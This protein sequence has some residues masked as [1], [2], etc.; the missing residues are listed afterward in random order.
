MAPLKNCVY[1]TLK[2]MDKNTKHT[3]THTN[4]YKYADG[5]FRVDLFVIVVAVFIP[6]GGGWLAWV[7]PFLEWLWELVQDVLICRLNNEIFL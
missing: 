2:H 7:S 1:D 3:D 4:M 6:S 5:I